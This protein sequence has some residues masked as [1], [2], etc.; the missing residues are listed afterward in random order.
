MPPAPA[1]DIWTHFRAFSALHWVTLA[2]CVAMIAGACVLGRRWREESGGKER[3][4]RHAWAWLILLMQ[5]PSQYYYMVAHWDIQRS[6]PL[7]VCDLSLFIAAGALLTETRWVRT[8]LYFW[9][10][11]LSTQ[12]FITPVIEEGLSTGTFWYFWINHLQIIGSA[13]YLVVVMGYRPAARDMGVAVVLSFV[14]VVAMVALDLA[15]GVNYGY[16]GNLTPKTP[17]LIDRLGAW[18]GRL[19]ILAAIVAV[20]YTAMWLVWPLSRMPS[21]RRRTR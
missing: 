15:L 2:V 9:G 17:T 5:I 18:P 1:S 12:G 10:L 13:V 11:G 3:R 14:Y 8:M 7:H 6:L 4:L 19:F 20:L 21:E 16:V